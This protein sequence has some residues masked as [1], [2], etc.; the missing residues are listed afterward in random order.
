[1]RR[2]LAGTIFLILFLLAVT[3]TASMLGVR[4][5]FRSQ[6]PS[7]YMTS[8]G[9]RVPQV[10]KSILWRSLFAH[11]AR[12]YAGEP[13]ELSERIAPVYIACGEEILLHTDTALESV[14]A[15]AVTPDGRQ[16]ALR[17]SAG[18]IVLPTDIDLYIITMNIR[19]RGAS[20]ES[21]IKV[22]T[23]PQIGVD[24]AIAKAA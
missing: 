8:G 7:L 22:Q 11:H 24:K 12:R 2:K 18:R 13:L 16:T 9:I 10:N 20:F 1:M 15:V 17:S 19:S 6:P 23:V 21:I 4:D 5:F 3:G 14:S